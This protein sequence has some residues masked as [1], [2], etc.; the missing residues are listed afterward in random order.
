MKTITAAFLGLVTVNSVAASMGPLPSWRD[1]L[2]RE[3]LVEF[4]NQVTTEGGAGYVPPADRIAV[5]D[6]DGTLWA[7]QPVYFQAAFIF[8]QVVALAPLYPNWK[9]TEPFASVLRG[10]LDSALA[11]GK[12]ALV[13]MM[14]ATHA[15][16]TSDE[17]E[18]RVRVWL[19]TASH[20]KTGRRYAEMVYQPMLEVLDHLRANEFKTFI[21]S[22]GGVDFMRVFAEE[23]YGIPP[24]QVIG[25]RIKAT[26]EIREGEPVIVKVAEL[27]FVDDKEGKPVG[28]YQHIGRRPI[29]AFGNSDGDF[30]MLEWTTAGAG[31]SLGVLVHHDDPD[32]EWAYDRD[33]HIGRLDRGLDEALDRGWLV[34]SMKDDWKVIFPPLNPTLPVQSTD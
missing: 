33:S 23:T 3:A 15:G 21:V 14:V 31:S 28:I 26:Y 17:F 32:R 27:E 9:D 5:F 30:Q 25:T 10:D 34:V 1:S 12:A 13:E 8:D 7:E 6:N 2:T 16:V 18:D 19:E 29:A 4:V 20:P 24:E 11:G 22:G